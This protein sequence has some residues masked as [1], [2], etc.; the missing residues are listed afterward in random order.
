MS[1]SWQSAC[2]A[3]S[4][5]ELELDCQHCMK[6]VAEFRSGHRSN[7]KFKVKPS[8]VVYAFNPSRGKHE[9]QAVSSLFS[10]L[11]FPNVRMTGMHSTI[12]SLDYSRS[13]LFIG[14]GISHHE[15]RALLLP[16]PPNSAPHRWDPHP[17]HIHKKS[18]L[19]CLYTYSVEL[20]LTAK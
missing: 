17:T 9:V 18:N 5:P 15:P 10:C 4:G 20:P 12:G 11:F 8:I 7:K 19:C 14:L 2:V 1:H 16:S 3:C 6:P 13:H